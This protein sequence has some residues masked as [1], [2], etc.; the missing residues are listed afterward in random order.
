V[1]KDDGRGLKWLKGSSY[2]Y[3]CLRMR[4]FSSIQARRLSALIPFP[5]SST[6]GGKSTRK[7]GMREEK[8]GWTEGDGSA[9]EH[10]RCGN[11]TDNSIRKD[12]V[13]S[14]PWQPQKYIHISVEAKRIA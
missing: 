10:L 6:A 9:F 4:L 11:K 7:G 8:E 2:Q 1:R 5:A 13:S 12:G 14:S 3:V